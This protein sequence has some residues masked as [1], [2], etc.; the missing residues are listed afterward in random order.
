MLI[1]AGSNPENLPYYKQRLEGVF[2][3][4]RDF[5]GNESLP[6]IMGELGT[7]VRNDKW[8]TNWGKINEIIHAIAD[9]SKYCYLVSTSDLD[10]NPDFVHFNSRSQRIMGKRYADKFISINPVH[11]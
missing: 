8:K 11:Q 2:A 4:M 10:P 6:I 5:I 3:N 7:Y 9:E 1:P